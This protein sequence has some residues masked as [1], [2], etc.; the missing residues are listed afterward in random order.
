MNLEWHPSDYL[1][2]FS[3]AIIWIALIPTLVGMVPVPYQVGTTNGDSM[4]PNLHG[5]EV[6]MVD[7]NV[8]FNEVE[9]GDIIKFQW[10]GEPVIHRYQG[11]GL[12]LGDG[13][14]DK[15]LYEKV[16]EENYIGKVSIITNITC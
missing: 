12:A 4:E 10:D 8:D 14:R 13:N 9:A 16:T 7:K 6:L 15:M 11:N 5:C 3:Q 2:L 1:M